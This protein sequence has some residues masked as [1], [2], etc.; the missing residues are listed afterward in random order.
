MSN[1]SPKPPYPKS[2]EPGDFSDPRRR[3]VWGLIRITHTIEDVRSEMDSVAVPSK[4]TRIF[5]L[6]R[7]IF[8]EAQQLPAKGDGRIHLF[9]D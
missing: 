3:P 6:G 4:V 8:E 9:D 1:S 7:C 2:P 5:L